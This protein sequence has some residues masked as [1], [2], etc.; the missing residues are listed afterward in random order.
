[1]ASPSPS[2]CGATSSDSSGGGGIHCRGTCPANYYS[3][4]LAWVP[5][6]ATTCGG[7]NI[8]PPGG[9]RPGDRDRGSVDAAPAGAGRPTGPERD[10]S[11]TCGASPTRHLSNNR[12]TRGDSGVRCAGV[13]FSE[14]R[15]TPAECRCD[16]NRAEC[17]A[18]PTTRDPAGRVAAFHIGG[19]TVSDSVPDE[20]GHAD[21]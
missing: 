6:H 1:M 11:L 14:P 7:T 18:L 17:R 19:R 15:P 9:S 8:G 4:S 10:H 2:S 13:R 21:G 20:S 3:D 16:G 5:F 12:R